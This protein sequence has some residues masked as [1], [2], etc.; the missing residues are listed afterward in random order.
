[1]PGMKKFKL[2]AV[3]S[4]V[5]FC[6]V[7]SAKAQIENGSFGYYTDA[8]R[9]SRLSATS[10]T[11]RMQAIGGASAALGG[12]ISTAASNPAGLGFFNRSVVVF[13]PSMNFNS[14]ETD[15]FGETTGNFVNNFN[16]SSLGVVFNFS[17]GDIIPEKYKGGSFAINFQRVNDFYNE[18][19]YEGYNDNNS[20]IDYFLQQAD[21]IPVGSIDNRGLTSLAYYNYL[22]NPVPDQ[23]GVYDSFVVG[24]PRQTETVRSTGGQNQWSFSYGGNYDDKLYFGVGLGI[25]SLRYRNAKDYREDSFYD[26]Q[27]EA[28]DP[29]IN[30]LSVN[31]SIEI[32][33]SGVN[34]TFGLIYRP[35]DLI[36]VGVS[37]ATPTLYSLSEQST[38]FLSTS[39]NDYYFAAED[40]VLG[41][42]S[43]E[44]DIVE[45]TYQMA[46]PGRLTAG[47]SVFAGKM[48]FV[49][50]DVELVDYSRA[51]LKSNDFSASADNRTI[52][53]LY[54][55][56]L[57]YRIGAEARLGIFRVRAGYA[58]LGD[59]YEDSGNSVGTQQAITGGV[60]LRV[61]NFFVDLGVASMSDSRT[62][63]PYVLGQGTPEV[64]VNNRSTRGMLTVGFVF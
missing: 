54:K 41:D 22:I 32:N 56:T 40:T 34:G 55:P 58:L 49:S 61:R 5:I 21:G 39:Y 11:A 16:L 52:G 51:R 47:V 2:I 53:N 60:G 29:A 3:L 13:T 10:G 26:F 37:Y 1:M 59:P 33:G 48:G 42:L 4:V 8:L 35:M 28:D 17:K 46:T 24:Y 12:D 57:N 30:S 38:S 36:R 15:F 44:G 25:M 20:I 62:Y 64:E 6:V 14:S 19:T 43:S 45:S 50:A 7:T 9:F 18:F 63:S 23:D 27:T 31:E